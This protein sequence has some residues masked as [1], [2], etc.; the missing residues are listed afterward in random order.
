VCQQICNRWIQRRRR[1]R[2]SVSKRMWITLA[3]I[4]SHKVANNIHVP[5]QYKFTVIQTKKLRHKRSPHCR[6]SSR[7]LSLP[8][9]LLL[10]PRTR[11]TAQNWNPSYFA[12][13]TN[14]GC[15][16]KGIGHKILLQYSHSCEGTRPT[17][18]QHGKSVPVSLWKCGETDVKPK[19]MI[20]WHKRQKQHANWH[21][22]LIIEI[23]KT[24]TF[25][26]KFSAL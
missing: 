20:Q 7:L 1:R 23:W 22:W 16:R 3:Y 12:N 13:W 26:T 11:L 24:T 15:V 19:M 8:C 18:V 9:E 6:I 5:L 25:N 21:R 17:H 4:K 2:E 10:A 14:W